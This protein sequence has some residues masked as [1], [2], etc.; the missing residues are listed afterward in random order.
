MTR[1]TRRV[2]TGHVSR[3]E[4]SVLMETSQSRLSKHGQMTLLDAA[5]TAFLNLYIHFS[6]SST[7]LRWVGAM[8]RAA[9]S[10]SIIIPRYYPGSASLCSR[11]K[12]SLVTCV[13]VHHIMYIV[14]HI[15]IISCTLHR[16][17][18]AGWWS[19]APSSPTA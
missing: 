4:V 16:A 15:C 14:H 7:F 10:D 18:G 2:M 8:F 13:H 3:C 17:A 9:R 19:S 5:Y 12:L 1:G 6:I 11:D